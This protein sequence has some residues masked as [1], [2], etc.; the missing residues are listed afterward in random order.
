MKMIID[1]EKVPVFN[2]TNLLDFLEE[3][4]IK[5]EKI[6]ESKMSIKNMIRDL[7]SRIKQK[8]RWIHDDESAIEDM[9]ETIA[10]LEELEGK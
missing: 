4:N 5:Y 3:K 1:L 8:E 9:K 10:E 2:V 7:K 6:K